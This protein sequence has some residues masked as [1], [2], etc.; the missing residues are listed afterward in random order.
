M[1]R[2]VHAH[3]RQQHR[4]QARRDGRALARGPAQALDRAPHRNLACRG[5][6]VHVRVEGDLRGLVVARLY[7]EEADRGCGNWACIGQALKCAWGLD[8]LDDYDYD[9]EEV[10]D[11]GRRTCTR[12]CPRWRG[13]SKP[14]H[15][16]LF[17]PSFLLRGIDKPAVH[18]AHNVGDNGS[19]LHNNAVIPRGQKGY[20]Y[21]IRERVPCEEC[22]PESR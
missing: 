14:S 20:T 7:E 5:D 4:L 22:L 21:Q 10:A 16:P 1:G 11:Q 17:R 8:H 2:Q 18:C 3:L 9:H 15:S 6:Q 12:T 19:G 13:R